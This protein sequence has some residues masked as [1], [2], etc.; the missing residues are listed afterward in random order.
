M[1]HSFPDVEKLAIEEMIEYFGGIEAFNK[2]NAEFHQ[3][4]QRMCNEEAALTEQYPC[5]WV[6]VGKDG[7][8]E[9]GDSMEGVF[10]AVESRG[11]KS[12]EFL[13]IFLDPN[14][15]LLIL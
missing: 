11:L 9:V 5:K 13:V 4:V 2:G 7:L 1:T 14:P 6:A 10:V 8:L 3:V 15:L 12:S